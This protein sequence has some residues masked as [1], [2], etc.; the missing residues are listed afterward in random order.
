MLNISGIFKNRVLNKSRLLAFGFTGTDEEYTAL[1]DILG[2]QF[3]IHIKVTDAGAVSV[4]VLDAESGEDYVLVHMP[5]AHG[6]FVG[7][8]IAACEERLQAVAESCFDYAV[9]RS[10]QSKQIVEYAAGKYHDRLEFLWEKF[11]GNA[12][13]RRR[14]S[15]KWY[16][17][18]LTVARSKLGLGGDG[19][20]EVI[21]LRAL[22]LEIET[23][24]DRKKYF[25]GYHMNKKH[26]Y[27]ICLDGSVSTQEICERIDVSY[28]LAKK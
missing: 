2:G 9:F 16:A 3:K 23:L 27:T 20:I 1:Y 11:A 28:S 5:D 21:D 7:S 19:T 17:A 25:P 18:L 22:P 13:L 15:K 10:E 26:W 14:D 8:V 12:V 4:K 24:I 6:A